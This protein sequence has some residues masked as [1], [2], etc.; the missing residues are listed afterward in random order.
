MVVCKG[1]KWECGWC[2]DLDKLST[3]LNAAMLN[4]EDSRCVH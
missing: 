2:D 3:L 1:N 4:N